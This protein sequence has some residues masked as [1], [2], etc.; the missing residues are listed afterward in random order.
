MTMAERNARTVTIASFET[1][2]EAAVVQALLEAEGITVHAANE[3][4]VRMLW[5]MSQA[6]GGV[7]IRVPADRAED[8][9]ALVRAYRRGELALDAGDGEAPVI[10]RCPACGSEAIEPV[11]PRNEKLLLGL[12]FVLF[13][14]LWPTRT[15]ERRCVDCGE[16]WT[17]GQLLP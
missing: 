7:Q 5:P 13:N 9:A 2:A 16:R 1:V 17:P 8:A 3:G 6:L 14:L 4:H 12:L 11:V 10:E 15:T